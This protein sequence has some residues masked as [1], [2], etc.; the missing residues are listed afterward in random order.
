[1]FQA[2]FQRVNLILGNETEKLFQ[3]QRKAGLG[4][5]EPTC[6][7]CS[8]LEQDLSMLSSELLKTFHIGKKYLV[9]GLQ[10]TPKLWK[11]EFQWG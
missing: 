10:P 3:I 7:K 6:R 11:M 1:M 2:L 5:K 8:L 4:Q 9:L